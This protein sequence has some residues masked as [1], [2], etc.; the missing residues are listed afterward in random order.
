MAKILIIDDDPNILRMLGFLLVKE[1]HTVSVARDGQSGI[2]MAREEWPDLIILDVMM[3]GMD[4]FCVSGA[5]F[6]DPEMRRI[7][8]L[9]LTAKGSSRE[10]FKLVPNVVH[11]MDKPFDPDDLVK[12]VRQLLF[13]P[14]S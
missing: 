13:P 1:G 14:K 5:L 2:E 7:P 11:Y 10:I 4:G 3:P 9:V 12:N 6:K 8:I